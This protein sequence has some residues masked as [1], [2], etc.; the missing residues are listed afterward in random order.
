MSTPV[1]E[2]PKI[3]STL[4]GELLQPAMR[5]INERTEL[6]VELIEHRKGAV[7]ESVQF[8]VARRPDLLNSNSSCTAFRLRMDRRPFRRGIN[9]F[10][11]RLVPPVSRQ[12]MDIQIRQQIVHLNRQS[13]G[14][15]I[16][17]SLVG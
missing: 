15:T 3:E 8:R 6:T 1:K 10:P 13:V 12:D 14:M 4:K 11:K 16:T 17:E 7:L 5:E 2:L 9:R